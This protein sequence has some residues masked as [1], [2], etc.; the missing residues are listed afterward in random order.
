[1]RILLMQLKNKY[2]TCLLYTSAKGA[3]EQITNIH[4]EWADTAFALLNVDGMYPISGQ[5][6][7]AITG[8][9]AS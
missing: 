4:P 1:M 8:L 6:D 7:F 5:K 2:N 3:Y 9:I